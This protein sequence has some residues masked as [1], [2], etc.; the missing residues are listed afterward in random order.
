MV[1]AANKARHQMI[2]GKMKTRTIHTELIFNLS[3]SHSVSVFK[4]LQDTLFYFEYLILYRFVS[5][6]RIDFNRMDLS[7]A[8]FMQIMLPPGF[9]EPE[10][11][12]VK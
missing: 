10:A 4:A 2:N 1:V 7:C 12:N 3:P 11:L 8:T 6:C 5:I 9:V